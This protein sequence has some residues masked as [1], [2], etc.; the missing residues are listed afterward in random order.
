MK[1]RLAVPLAA[2]VVAACGAPPT[3]TSAPETPTAAPAAAGKQIPSGAALSD[4]RK[5][6]LPVPE[7]AL[8]VDQKPW[9]LDYEVGKFGGNLVSPVF[10]EAKTFNWIVSNENSTSEI[11]HR[12]VADLVHVN[13]YTQEVELALAKSYAVAEDGRSMTLVLRKGVQW[14]DGEPFD[15]D[16][17]VFT[18]HAIFDEKVRSPQADLLAIDGKPITIAKVDDHTVRLD[19]P[20]TMAAPERLL[21]SIWILPEHK[22]GKT[23]ADGTFSSSWGVSMAPA[24]FVTLGPFRLERYEAGQKTVL[25]R[26]PYFYKFDRE[27]QRLPYLDEITFLTVP[28]RNA[29]RL[30]YE[31]LE[32]HVLNEPRQEDIASLKALAVEKDWAVHDLGPSLST[33]FFWFN[34]NLA[35]SAAVDGKSYMVF[36]DGTVKE[37]SRTVE[38]AEKA[39][40][41]AAPHKP[42]VDP[43]KVKWFRNQ[44]FRQAVSHAI[45]REGIIRSVFY[46]L[47]TPLYSSTSPGNKVWYDPNVTTYPYDLARSAQLLEEAGFKKDG[48][49]ML[50]DA[51]G[52]A[53]AFI[54]TTNK[55]NEAREKMGN[56]IKEDLA[57]L[58]M[59]VDFRPTD[60]NSFITQLNSTFDWEAAILG[61]GG[62]DVDPS[63][64]LNVW[65]SSGFTHMWY[66]F[67]PTP[68]TDYEKRID[69]LLTVIQTS[70]D[71]DERKK[72]DWEIQ[73]TI[74]D[75]QPLNYTLCVKLFTTARNC[76]GNFR[77][78]VMDHFSLHNQ[79]FLYFKY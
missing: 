49:G 55:G 39:K 56:I 69:D 19:F 79:E 45:N 6:E 3:T 34:Q 78:A 74:A 30:R 60:F 23:L 13:R 29:E 58:G 36:P 18:W 64:G 77:P 10:T 75:Q 32:C 26:N 76:V 33:N 5:D 37:Q 8:V 41:A 54:L 70:R 72:A 52:N 27:R 25:E 9:D 1:L 24:D 38:G 40:V 16:D 67:Q 7:D 43:V 44:K 14:S 46:G 71:R 47:G 31:S 57:T 59:Q 73:A 2:L 22:L 63:G 4:S 50:R 61:L 65:K 21:D 66:P 17:V 35:S 42:F 11:L 68:S 28:D 12:M 53:V 51:D 20:T 48:G 15:A 62:G